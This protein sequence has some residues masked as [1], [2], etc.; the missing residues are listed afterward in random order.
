MTSGSNFYQWTLILCLTASIDIS[1]LA[2]RPEHPLFYLGVFSL[3][4]ALRLFTFVGHWYSLT[5][6]RV[7]LILCSVLSYKLLIF[8][9]LFVPP[10]WWLVLFIMGYIVVID[11][12]MFK[13]A[14]D[15]TPVL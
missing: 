2:T 14:Y 4:M 11:V 9:F 13:A 12:L 15:D 8:V 3:L 7:W 6:I 1:R 5:A 10:P